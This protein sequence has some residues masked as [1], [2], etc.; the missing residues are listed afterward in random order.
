MKTSTSIL[1]LAVAA[2]GVV[3]CAANSLPVDPGATY[4]ED[5]L[6]ADGQCIHRQKKCTVGGT[7]CCTGF[8]AD[9][10]Y[11]SGLCSALLDD[12]AYCTTKD[13]CKSGACAGNVCGGSCVAA[14]KTCKTS[15][16]CCGGSFCDTDTYGPY[17]CKAPQPD[18]SYCS[19]DDQCLNRHC[20]GYVC[21]AQVACRATTES[22]QQDTDCCAGFC[23]NTTY[24][25]WVCTAPTANGT[26]CFADSH[27]QSHHCVSYS[28]AP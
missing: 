18:G 17:A 3:S 24:A 12:G 13:Q 23:E 11:G 21:T 20:T 26:Y 19:S 7:R 22:C 28:C 25:P 27:C 16:D 6:K 4:D 8:C 15:S 1:W 2:A 10:G 14:G 5:L 9:S